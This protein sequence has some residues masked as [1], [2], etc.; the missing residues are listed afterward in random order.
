MQIGNID[1]E[2]A[3]LVATRL[4]FP[5]FL[6]GTFSWL[7]ME[8]SGREYF[9]GT[10]GEEADLPIA[11][12]RETLYQGERLPRCWQYDPGGGVLIHSLYE[13]YCLGQTSTVWFGRVP[14][15]VGEVRP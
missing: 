4:G 5:L 8:G 9:P 12:D 6:G 1:L 2:K 10:V 7:S 11:S 14:R 13:S 3:Q 15:V